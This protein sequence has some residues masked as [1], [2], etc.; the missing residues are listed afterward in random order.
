MDMELDAQKQRQA[1]HTRQDAH[2]ERLRLHLHFRGLVL[3]DKVVDL[4]YVGECVL[5]YGRHH[6]HRRAEL[7][8]AQLALVA[9]A[10]NKSRP[11]G[12]VLA[13]AFNIDIKRSDLLKLK[14]LDWLNDECINFFMELIADRSANPKRTYDRPLPKVIAMRTHKHKRVFAG[15]RI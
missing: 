12:E 1:R 9:S 10:W 8:D 15:L 11:G 13:S 14:G 2:N 4:D 7:H 6:H 5:A 3:P